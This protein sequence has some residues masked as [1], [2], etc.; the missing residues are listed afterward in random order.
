LR[1]LAGGLVGAVLG[2]P[3]DSLEQ[4]KMPALPTAKAAEPVPS[5]VRKRRRLTP[6]GAGSTSRLRFSFLI[7]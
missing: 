5:K 3:C 4:P 7:R 1:L 6:A 2:G